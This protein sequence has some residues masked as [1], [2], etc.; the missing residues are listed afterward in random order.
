MRA[1]FLLIVIFMVFGLFFW[2]SLSGALFFLSLLALL[3]FLLISVGYYDSA[4]LFFLGAR[5][6]R[7]SSGQQNFIQAS[8]QEAYKLSV[9]IPNLYFYNGNLNRSFVIQR[10]KTVSLILEKSLLTSL[11]D[12]ELSAICFLLLLQ[13][14]KGLA[15][16]R[17]LAT[18]ILGF[19][20][21]MVHSVVAVIVRL[22]PGKEI[23]QSFCWLFNFL[24]QPWLTFL[25]NNMI[26]EGYFKKLENF[27]KEFP[28]EN[29]RIKTLGL[30]LDLPEHMKSLPSRKL[31]ELMAIQKN[32]HFQIILS[33]ESL[34]HE[35][36]MF[37]R[38]KGLLSDQ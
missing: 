18:F 1:A 12:E 25:F 11:N 28:V 3:V 21:W 23:K 7:E 22:I 32:Q 5:A 19:N 14:K 10:G 35:W 33:L 34:P 15:K 17:S 36:D 16:K 9:P 8:K 27:L 29:A 37:F 30:K 38:D 13:V 4:L 26:G 6:I 2:A 31:V 20:A 24:L